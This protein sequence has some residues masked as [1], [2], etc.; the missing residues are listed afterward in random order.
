MLRREVRLRRE[1]LYRKSLQGK[2]LDEYQHQQAI[3]QSLANG[4]PLPTE[5]QG[6][7]N[8]A[9]IKSTE[10]IDTLH[11]T[12]TVQNIDDEYSH[13]GQYE[14]KLLLT[15]SRQ[16]SSKLSQFTKELKLVFPNTTRINR[17]SLILS[18]LIE[19]SNASSFTDLVIVHETRGI[20]DTLT[21]THLPFGPTVYFNLS[22]V[23]MRH[24]IE[25]SKSVLGTISQVYPKLIFDGFSSTSRLSLRLQTVLKALFPALPMDSNDKSNLRIVSFSN[26]DDILS[27]RHHLYKKVS[28]SDDTEDGRGE[29]R[30]M[31]L[32]EIGPRFE[33]K[34]FHIKLGTLDMKD[35]DDEWVLRPYMNTAKKRRILS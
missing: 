19:I 27:F 33:M 22:N 24:D 5:Y 13:L 32:K 9:N 18:Q 8:S 15:T 12:P 30:T 34:L 2:Q 28:D 26:R 14:P 3:R 31:E 10:F 20:P 23:V 35:A 16:P 17:G 29:K 25:N 11:E 1:Y 7:T 6:S 4:T 21:I